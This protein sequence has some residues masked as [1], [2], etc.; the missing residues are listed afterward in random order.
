[1]LIGII[2]QRI[3]TTALSPRREVTYLCS[4]N[5]KQLKLYDYGE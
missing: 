4:V 1:M 2:V 3:G 5:V